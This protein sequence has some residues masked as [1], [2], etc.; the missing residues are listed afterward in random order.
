LFVWI[1]MASKIKSKSKITN[2]CT[3]TLR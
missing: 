3:M 1:R 2:K